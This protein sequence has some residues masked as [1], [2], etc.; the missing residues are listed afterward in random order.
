MAQLPRYQETGLVSGDVPRLDFA[1]LR[2]QAQGMQSVSGALDRISQF[3]FG[4][5]KKEKDRMDQLSDIQARFELEGVVS[6][7]IEKIT[8]E[9]KTGKLL[10]INAVQARIQAM[11]GLA[12]AGLKTVEQQ[13]GLMQSI[14]T[15]GRAVMSAASDIFVKA[16]Q[17]EAD[18]KIGQYNSSASVVFQNYFQTEQS[19]ESVL[20]KKYQE[21]GVIMNLAK[22][23]GGNVKAAVD[24]FEASFAT[25]RSN[26]IREF[27]NGSDDPVIA[28]QL[29]KAG[30]SPNQMINQM[31]QTGEKANVLKAADEAMADYNKTVDNVTKV[32][33]ERAKVIEVEWADAIRSGNDETIKSVLARTRIYD[34]NNYEKRMAQYESTGG[35]FGVTNNALIIKGFDERLADPYGKNPL[36]IKELTENASKMT[37][38]KY[39]SYLDRIKSFSDSRVKIMRERAA[40][41]LGMTPGPV[42][43]KDA[44]R[45]MQEAKMNKL[46][47]EWIDA[48]SQNPNLDPMTWFAENKEKI[49]K[50]AG[51]KVTTDIQAK[52]AGR[53]IKTEAGFN[54]AIREAQQLGKT[55]DVARLTIELNELRQ[56][57]KDGLVDK[58]GQPIKSGAKE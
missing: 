30:K 35:M 50:T 16:S 18:Y 15:K 28:Y 43:M 47:V 45:Q 46:D 52:V 9:V 55:D 4:E 56:A 3:A 22:I 58:N 42:L 24:G 23:N 39:S 17:D 38:E 54:K 21:A 6:Q 33:A 41:E 29:I 19:F 14:A 32:N 57:I 2:E 31:M 10:D 53:T 20:V 1:N 51:Q 40:S 37:Q 7:E 25:A 13:Q 12:Q 44:A 49:F 48:R 34:G 26:F 5:M 8:R 36:T 11:S 27:I